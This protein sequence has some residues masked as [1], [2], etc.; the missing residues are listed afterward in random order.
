LVLPGF[1]GRGLGDRWPA[2]QDRGDWELI[3]FVGNDESQFI[4]GGIPV[5]GAENGD[6]E[7]KTARQSK[8]GADRPASPKISCYHEACDRIDNV[9]RDL[10]S[11]YLRALAGTLADYATSTDELR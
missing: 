8:P 6:E 9:N 2:G 10:L 1:D 3:E 5:G 4:E 7:E 11:H